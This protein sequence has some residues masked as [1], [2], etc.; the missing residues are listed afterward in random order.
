MIGLILTLSYFL[1]TVNSNKEKLS[2]VLHSSSGLAPPSGRVFAFV[3]QIQ[4]FLYR[5]SSVSIP[6]F[7]GTN[8]V[9]TSLRYVTGPQVLLTVAG[10]GLFAA[11]APR[12]RSGLTLSV[13]EWVV[14]SGGFWLSALL[15]VQLTGAV[16]FKL[17][18]WI[19][20]YGPWTKL[21]TGLYALILTV[22]GISGRMAI[23]VIGG[24]RP[25]ALPGL[26]LAG[27]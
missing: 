11:F 26:T 13:V 10:I 24:F 7:A 20:N 8:S 9:K 25:P 17:S 21:L 14:V 22:A 3:N 1:T 2:P 4:A 23:V 6:A 18:L 12:L 19:M 15:A 16:L 5:F 27:T